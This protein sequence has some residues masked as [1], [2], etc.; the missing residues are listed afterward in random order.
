MSTSHTLLTKAVVN[1]AMPAPA[2]VISEQT[3]YDRG[4]ASDIEH[5]TEFARVPDG[6]E[7]LW[8][9]H[10]MAYIQSKKTVHEDACPFCDAQGK[11][12]AE[13]LIVHR[14]SSCFVIMNLFPYNT[15][16]LLICPRRHIPSYVDLTADETLEFTA[17]T[18]QAVHALANATAP[19]GFNLGMN[20]GAAAG[21]GIAAHLHQHVVPRWNGDA[22][23]LPII[24]QT[25]AL[26]EFLEDAREG[27]A[28]AWPQD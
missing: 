21:A 7:R 10:R 5:E 4:M 24:A 8:T 20:Q 23:F 16:H 17:L 19:H 12:D 6:F 18:K 9:P 11:S 28:A 22:N 1:I 27:L 13:A 14:K 26:P 15:G 3:P 25:K 2:W